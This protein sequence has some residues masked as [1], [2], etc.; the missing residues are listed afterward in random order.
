[1]QVEERLDL[2]YR[3]RKKYGPTV[4]DMLS[5]L[6]RCRKELDQI[7]YADDTLARLEEAID[8]FAKLK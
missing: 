7:Q 3:L 1:M 5:D 2:L 8:Q 4:E 6:E